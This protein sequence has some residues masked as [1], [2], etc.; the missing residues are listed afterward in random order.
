MPCEHEKNSNTLKLACRGIDSY[1]YASLEK[2]VLQIQHIPT[3]SRGGGVGG[4]A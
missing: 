3:P 4:V 2:D 1:L